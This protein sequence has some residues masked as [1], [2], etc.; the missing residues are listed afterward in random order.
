MHVISRKALRRFWDPH[1]ES[2]VPLVRWFKIMR[3]TDFETFGELRAVFPS[4]DKVA[5]WIVFN[6]GG[7]KFRLITSVH[8]NR[9]KV[10]IRHVLTH[11]DYDRGNW[12]Q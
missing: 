8:F 6:V 9:G 10:Y 7:N 5:D 2:E 1:P 11:R 4:A 12:K 3:H